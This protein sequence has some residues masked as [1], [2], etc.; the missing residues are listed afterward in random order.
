MN[1]KLISAKLC[2]DNDSIYWKLTLADNSG[3]IIGTF[4]TKSNTLDFRTFTFGLI[5]ILNNQ[6]L[7]AL[8][9]QNISA[10]IL[11]KSSPTRIESIGN[12]EGHFLTIDSNAQISYGT[13]FDMSLY[14]KA[15]LTTLES[16][17]GILCARIEGK[18]WTQYLQAPEAYKGFKYV[19]DVDS[20]LNQQIYGANYFSMFIYQI[21]N[22]CKIDDLITH[23]K[24]NYPEV[25]IVLD[26]KSEILAIG[27][28]AQSNWLAITDKGYILSN[29]SIQQIILNSNK[30]TK[31]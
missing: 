1:G 19:Y 8:T 12:E 24:S 17:S 31:R 10:P 9:D 25:S 11:V 27:N 30:N 2:H 29:T 18:Y 28:I 15:K 23:S 16:K 6:N 22:I 4:G 20:S 3:N 7:F 21:L 5:K 14:E 26:D 13:G